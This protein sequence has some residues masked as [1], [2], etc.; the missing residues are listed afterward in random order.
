MS[1]I[2]LRIKAMIASLFE[3]KSL[4]KAL[5]QIFPG[6]VIQLK[7]MVTWTGA[8]INIVT[9]LKMPLQDLSILGLLRPDMKSLNATLKECFVW[10]VFSCGYL[11]RPRHLTEHGNN[12]TD[13]R[14]C[15]VCFFS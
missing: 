13:E 8:C 10:G 15:K 11:C 7:I 12:S 9:L 2:S 14:S 5:F 4:K 3:I 1:L 6:K